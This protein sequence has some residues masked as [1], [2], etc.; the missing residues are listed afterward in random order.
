MGHDIQVRS[1]LRYGYSR[2]Q[3][4]ER[5]DVGVLKS[6]I[7]GDLTTIHRECRKN[8]SPTRAKTRRHDCD[9][10]VEGATEIEGLPQNVRIAVEL[11]L[12]HLISHHEDRRRAWFGVVGRD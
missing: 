9:Q 8:V 1:G 3:I 7:L 12:P 4:A 10:R 5:P 2:L 6:G 11:I